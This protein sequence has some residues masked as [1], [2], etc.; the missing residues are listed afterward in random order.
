[1]LNFAKNKMLNFAKNREETTWKDSE[2]PQK[3]EKV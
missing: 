3:T 2:K 1:M